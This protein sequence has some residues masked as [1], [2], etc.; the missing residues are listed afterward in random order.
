MS[1]DIELKLYHLYAAKDG[2]THLTP[3]GADKI[4]D[5]FVAYGLKEAATQERERIVG[6]LNKFKDS[7]GFEQPLENGET[8]HAYWISNKNWR[9]ICEEK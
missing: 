2:H 7:K 6:I 1:K 5:E 8:M 4:Y 9:E 3:R